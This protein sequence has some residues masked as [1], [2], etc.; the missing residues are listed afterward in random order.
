MLTSEFDFKYPESQ[1]AYRPAARG[2]SRMLVIYRDGKF[3]ADFP[4][5]IEKEGW[6]FGK[7]SDLP[8][9]L[10]PGDALALNETK[11]V[12][13][14]LYGKFP[15]GSDCKMLAMKARLKDGVE[16]WEC[17]FHPAAKAV[18][19]TQMDFP[20]GLSGRVTEILPQGD[21]V[22]RF[23]LAD[24]EFLD[25]LEEIGEIPLP[26]YMKR[27]PD[28]EDEKTYQSVFA[29]EPGSVAAPTASLHF[30][31]E[32]LEEIA[33]KGVDIAKL[34]LHVGMGTFRSVMT[35]VAENH[36][37]HS[38]WYDL[39]PAAARALNAARKRGGRIF[40]VG[41]TAA[42]TLVTFADASGVLRPQ[43]GDTN[44]FILPGYSWKAADALLT[45]FHF[46]RSTLFML[47]C[48]R[49][50]T[51]RAKAAYAEAIGRGFKLFSYGDAML[52]L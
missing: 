32:M 44:L 34:T 6:A 45:N 43:S 21:R 40:A 18:V 15:D 16:E 20:S 23:N 24:R 27:R 22:I 36:P 17:L 12:R 51:E 5:P 48:S 14:R 13:A 52:I 26:L 4:L 50:G 11:V 41:T 19:G 46:P 25:K 10:K 8:L 9:F 28:A 38:E 29:R 33:R 3:T 47:V 7:T 31:T 35:P 49:V 1:I 2:E 39:S 42:R 37:M 30:S